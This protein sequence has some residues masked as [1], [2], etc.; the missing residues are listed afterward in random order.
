TGI[1][2]NYGSDGWCCIRSDSHDGL[3][4][5]GIWSWCDG[6]F[7]HR[8]RFRRDGDFYDQFLFRGGG[9]NSETVTSSRCHWVDVASCDDYFSLT[10]S[11]G[12]RN[13]VLAGRWVGSNYLEFG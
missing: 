13:G 7:I 10:I 6:E 11:I 12:K 4:P 5:V 2:L 9:V 8:C 3:I 1:P